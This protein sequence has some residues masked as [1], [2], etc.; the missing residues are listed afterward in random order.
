MGDLAAREQAQLG[1]KKLEDAMVMLLA[2]TPGGLSVDDIARELG[3]DTGLPHSRHNVIASAV[4][5]V[6][7]HTGRIS[8]DEENGVW[9]DNPQMG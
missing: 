9:R 5:E 4:L 3:L 1:L 6:L 2:R 8:W 7:V